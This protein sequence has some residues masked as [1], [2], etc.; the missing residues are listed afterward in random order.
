MT[1]Y[2]RENIEMSR[3]AILVYGFLCYAIGLGG[4]GVFILFAGG[5]DDRL[6]IR[7]NSNSPVQTCHGSAG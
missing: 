3:S 4:L 7:I 5:W 2:D 6:P 1:V